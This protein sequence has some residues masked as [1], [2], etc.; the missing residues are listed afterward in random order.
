MAWYYGDGNL[1][2]VETLYS[3]TFTGPNP[4]D[5]KLVAVCLRLD[6]VRVAQV[7]LH[8]PCAQ[9][10][11]LPAE[12]EIRHLYTDIE[13]RRRTRQEEQE[14]EVETAQQQ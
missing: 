13:A 12:A 14:T 6:F 3:F 10:R 11:S 9:E 1:T 8:G 4:S 7:L 2:G 5:E